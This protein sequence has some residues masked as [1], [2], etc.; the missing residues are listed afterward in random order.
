V[1]TLESG[2]T[3]LNERKFNSVA[4]RTIIDYIERITAEVVSSEITPIRALSMAVDSE[5][6]LLE[7]DFFE[8]FESDTID[9]KSGFRE[10]RAHEEKHREFIEERLKAE[11]RKRGR[12]G[13]P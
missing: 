5:R 8:V 10:L 3:L 13:R 9:M 4:V 1:K 2:N 7:R 12:G 11:K 6:S